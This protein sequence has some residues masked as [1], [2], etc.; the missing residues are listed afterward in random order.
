MKY[1]FEI[2]IQSWTNKK[3]SRMYEVQRLR[4]WNRETLYKKNWI[5]FWKIGNINQLYSVWIIIPMKV[6]WSYCVQFL[7]DQNLICARWAIK[8]YFVL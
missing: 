6:M 7:G 5:I 3:N 4:G 2:E 1:T 8:F